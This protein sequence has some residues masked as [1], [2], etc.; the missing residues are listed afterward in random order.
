MELNTTVELQNG[1]IGT[2]VGKMLYQGRLA[3][4]FDCE[5]VR[6]C[7]RQG[8][9]VAVHNAKPLPSVADTIPPVLAQPSFDS[10]AEYAFQTSLDERKFASERTILETEIKAHQEAIQQRLESIKSLERMRKSARLESRKLLKRGFCVEAVIAQLR[11]VFPRY[12][13]R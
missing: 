9:I 6:T 3:Y 11:A 1:R 7:I 2:I 10:Q 4:E 5:G 8:D 12:A 13:L